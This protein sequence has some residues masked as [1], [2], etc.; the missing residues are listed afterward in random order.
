MTFCRLEGALEIVDFVGGP[1][2]GKGLVDEDAFV[3]LVMAEEL[4]LPP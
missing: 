1:S 4:L 2:G 3:G